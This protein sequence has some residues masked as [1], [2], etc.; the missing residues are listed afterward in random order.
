[1]TV[2]SKVGAADTSAV[3]AGKL[4]WRFGCLCC[5]LSFS[6][7]L[8]D[9]V[10]P[11]CFEGF[12]CFSRQCAPSSAILCTLLKLLCCDASVGDVGLDAV[13]EALQWPALLS[14][15]L[16]ELAIEELLW[17]SVT[18]HPD[19]MPRPSELGFENHSLNA[20]G[21]CTIQDLKVCDPVLSFDA[22]D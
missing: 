12:C 9:D 16:T 20:G 1:M 21:F 19:D 22:Q 3:G 15:P 5:C 18:V 11:I 10:A 14:L 7:G 8:S 17:D 6:M 4:A 2:E 13:F